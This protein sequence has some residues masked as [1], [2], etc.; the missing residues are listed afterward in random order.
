MSRTAGVLFPAEAGYFSHSTPSTL[1]QPPIKWVRGAYFLGV[2][3]LE[4]EADDSHPFS[5]EVKKLWIYTSTA[6]HV[7]IAWR[8]VS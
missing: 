7:F 8:L 3:R 5:A 4:L 2:K 6:P 1:I